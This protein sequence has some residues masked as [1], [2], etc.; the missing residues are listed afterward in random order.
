MPLTPTD[1]IDY[2]HREESLETDDGSPWPTAGADDELRRVEWTDLLPA[3]HPMRDG[4]DWDLYGD[5][6]SPELSED[7]MGRLRE[8]CGL[9]A[10]SLDE[11]APSRR[12]DVCAWYQPMH[13]HGLDWGIYIREDCLLKIAADISAFL[14]AWIQPTYLLGKALVRAAFATLFLHEA[15][16][17]KTESLGIRLHVVERAACYGAYLRSVYKP[18]LAAGS[19]DLHEEALANADSFRRLAEAAHSRW[20]SRP[21]LNATFEYLRWR[22]VFD[23]PGYRQASN[24]IIGA[25][26]DDYEHLLKSQVQE[27]VTTPT[28]SAADWQL[29]PRMNQ[30]LFDCRSDIWT[31]V[32]AGT[33]PILPTAPPYPVVSTNVL[34]HALTRIGYRRVK[35]GN[36]SHI[37]LAATG[38]P[39]II[40]PANR[41]GLSPV[42]VRNVAKALGYRNANDLVVGLGL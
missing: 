39:T 31:I 4:D 34:T 16:H 18:L 42:V 2:L 27:Q 28:R 32:A 13:F 29:A 37:K 19:D 33:R 20:L 36:G 21:V 7:F 38:R 25:S 3:R 6:W 22:F 26:F 5:D 40:L 35:G 14:P 23:P 24:L 17:H 12:P 1:I 41:E 15:Y 9:G 30:S 8:H 10:D 11:N